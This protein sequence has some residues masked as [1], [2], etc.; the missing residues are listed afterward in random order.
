[1]KSHHAGLSGNIF[2]GIAM[3]KAVVAATVGLLLVAGQA[4]AANNSAVTR[5]SDRVGARAENSQDAF[6]ALPIW[7]VIGGVLT[8]VGFVYVVTDD[9]TDS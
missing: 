2:K 9:A 8:L 4:A 7:A 6:G 3:R 1:M 5:V